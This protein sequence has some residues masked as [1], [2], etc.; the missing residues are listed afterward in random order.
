MKYEF[1]IALSFA[2][3]EQNLVEKVYYYLKAEGISTF[4][5]PSPEGQTFLSGKNQREIFYDIF[6]LKSEY[7]ALFISKNYITREVP[8]EEASIAFSKHSSDGKVI[9]IY[10]DGTAL[11]LDMLDPRKINYFKSNNPV[12]IANHLAA[13]I[14]SVD[15]SYKKN[16]APIEPRGVM[17]IKNNT[18]EKQIFIQQLDGS[19]NL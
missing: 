1:K 12:T 19:I 8:M 3:E 10:L 15:S 13:K 2:T 18:A 17:N 4:F 9:P 7:V 6:G 14:K 5:A 11:P 16:S